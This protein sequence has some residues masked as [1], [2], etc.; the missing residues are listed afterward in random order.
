MKASQ[1]VGQ[2]Q[3]VFKPAKLNNDIKVRYEQV[4][5]FLL[6]IFYKLRFHYTAITSEAFSFF[7]AQISSFHFFFFII[8]HK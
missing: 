8:S 4:K 3:H 5:Q 6:E 7:V 2:D 1:K